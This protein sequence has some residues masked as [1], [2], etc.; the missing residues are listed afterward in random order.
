MYLQPILMRCLGFLTIFCSL[1]ACSM[2][3]DYQD[4]SFISSKKVKLTSDVVYKAPE[5]AVDKHDDYIDVSYHFF[6]G[7]VVRSNSPVGPFHYM[8]VPKLGKMGEAGAPALP[9]RN[10]LF[11]IPW[12]A[13]PRVEIISVKYVVYDNLLIYP[14]QPP[15]P[16][17]YGAKAPPFTINKILYASN[18]WFPSQVASIYSDQKAAQ[19]RYLRVQVVAAQQQPA[20]KKLRV[21]SEVRYRLHFR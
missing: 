17:V 6:G 1:F 2:T 15:A 5:G 19:K 4:S 7:K 11:E 13:T 14:A 10:D 16:D 12:D 18:E 8:H 9:M 21:L 3:Q 20:S